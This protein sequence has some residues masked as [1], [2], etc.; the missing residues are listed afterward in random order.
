LLD[1]WADDVSVEGRIA[2]LEKMGRPT[3]SDGEPPQLTIQSRGAAVPH[4]GLT[5]VISSIAWGDALMN[6]AGN[7]VRQFVTL[8]LVEYVE[9]VYLQERSAAN[10]R[11]KKRALAKKKRGAK[12]KRVKVARGRGTTATAHAL[13]LSPDEFGAGEDLLSIAARELGDAG[14]WPEI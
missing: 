4:L 9:D 5:W 11:R 8:T 10:R 1:G 13:S 2:D 14:R 12:A 3:A 7:R 6:A